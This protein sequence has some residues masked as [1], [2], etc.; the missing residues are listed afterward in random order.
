MKFIFFF[1]PHLVRHTHT[2]HKASS[3]SSILTI[4]PAFTHFRGALVA[5]SS[6]LGSSDFRLWYTAVYATHI[7]LRR[8]ARFGVLLH[9]TTTKFF[10]VVAWCGSSSFFFLLQGFAATF[11]LSYEDDDEM[12]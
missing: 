5:G 3:T 8:H 6:R 1:E 7:Y 12:M 4:I 2:L 9:T 11:S 10:N